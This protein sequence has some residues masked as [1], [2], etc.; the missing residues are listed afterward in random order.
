MLGRGKNNPKMFSAWKWWWWYC[1][2]CTSTAASLMEQWIL[3]IFD[4]AARN[5]THVLVLKKKFIFWNVEVL[6]IIQFKSCK[7]S[8]TN[9]YTKK[10]LKSSKSDPNSNCCTAVKFGRTEQN[11]CCLS[12]HLNYNQKQYFYLMVLRVWF[13]PVCNDSVFCFM[14]CLLC[15]ILNVHRFGLWRV[16]YECRDVAGWTR[17]KLTCVHRW[18][19]CFFKGLSI[20]LSAWMSIIFG[21]LFMLG[22]Q[23]KK[24]IQKSAPQSQIY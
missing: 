2:F 20:L 12:S 5:P 22:T 6:T 10:D 3:G 8:S 11:L 7:R 19:I 18:S 15:C 16:F 14:C 24:K 4:H 1:V 23:K 21:L 13:V 9:C 17:W